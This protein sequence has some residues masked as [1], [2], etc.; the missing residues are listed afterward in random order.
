M[1]P[2]VPPDP[3]LTARG[4]VPVALSL[5]PI[6]AVLEIP[7]KDCPYDPSQDGLFQ[8]VKHLLGTS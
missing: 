6:P 5:Q 4:V 2:T 1:P 7:S 3:P 8:R